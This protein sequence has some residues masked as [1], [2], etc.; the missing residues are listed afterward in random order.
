MKRPEQLDV[1]PQIGKWLALSSIVGILAGTASAAFLAALEWVTAWRENHVWIIAWLPAAGLFIGWVYFTFGQ[2]VE[3]GNN[4]L[5]DEIHNPKK[6]VPLRMT[7]LVLAGSV[8]THL[9]GGSAGRE[10][11]AIQM[12]G[13]LADQLCRPFKLSAEDRRIMLMAG[14]SGGFASVFGTPLA[15]TVFGLEV[16]AIGRL[17]YDALFPCLIAAVVGH[18][19]TLA[20][21]I[22]HSSYQ[23]PLSPPFTNMGL[24]YAVVAGAIFGIVGM[25][26]AQSTHATNA[27]FKKRIAYP[28]FRLVVGGAL[29]ALAVWLTGSTRY[30]GLGLP[31]IREAFTGLLHPWDFAGKFIMTVIT[32]GSGFKGGE[33][34]P[35]FYI[36]AAL[37]NT[38]SRILPL[39]APLLAG[40]GFAAVFAGAS[41]T[42]LACTLMAIEL[43]GHETALYMMIACV[44]S[45]LFSG[46][47]GIYRSQRIGSSKHKSRR[48][49]E[50]LTLQELSADPKAPS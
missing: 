49:E 40:M 9:F 48:H 29:V 17:R 33:V 4:L 21:G 45:Y 23:I 36:G 42:P 26:F 46:H 22:V 16:L 47:T 28:P 35:L 6:M 13:S 19:V 30:I 2:N 14:I 7:P 8:L 24:L 12:G 18:H 44:V 11:T 5:L 39:P 38:L 15:G 43:F 3:A 27:Y 25:L 37:G 32:L 41:N 50:G 34:T 20:W 31:I 10:G 1:L